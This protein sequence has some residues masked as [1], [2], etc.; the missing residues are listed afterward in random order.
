MYVLIHIT[1]RLVILS[2]IVSV[3]GVCPSEWNNSASDGRIL[4][5]SDI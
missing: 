5:K 1:F 3:C 4:I 2:F